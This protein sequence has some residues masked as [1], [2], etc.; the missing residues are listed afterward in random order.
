MEFGL[1]DSGG[2]RGITPECAHVHTTVSAVGGFGPTSRTQTFSS[3]FRNLYAWMSCVHDA[4]RCHGEFSWHLNCETHS[5]ARL[6]RI[7]SPSECSVS[8]SCRAMTWPFLLL[9]VAV[10]TGCGGAQDELEFNA[11]ESA[12]QLDPKLQ[13]HIERELLKEVGTF[14]EPVMLGDDR[15]TTA[16]LLKG[17]AVYQ[18]RCVQCHGVT[19]EGD[20]PTA[21]SM[22]PRPRDYSMG[23]FKFTSTTYGSK[24]M[25]DDL[26]HTVTNGIRGTSMPDFK[27]IPP[28]EIEA[29]VDYVIYLS[30]RGELEDKL[31]YLLG[32]AF[33]GVDPDEIT[34]QMISEIIEDENPVEIVAGSWGRA[35]ESQVLPMTPEPVFTPEHVARGRMAFLDGGTSCFNCHGID[36]RGQTRENLRG[37]RLDTWGNITR[38]ADLTSGML[39]GGRRPIDIYRRIF[40]GINGTPMPAY[41]NNFRDNPD[42]I[43]DLV[44]YVMYL[45]DRRRVGEASAPGPMAPYG[46][47]FDY[48]AWEASMGTAAE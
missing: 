22:Y 23:I 16:W 2:S 13:I 1:R 10:A 6:K 48:D 37:E 38:A 30:R 44:A 45:S 17:Q 26:I 47:Q 40:A 39:H 19:G 25:R 31:T 11:S 33:D 24:P 32:D 35:A 3:Q 41:A 9:F 43:W 20:G 27:L 15:V 5:R 42:K 28:D 36:G 7:E 34:D 14:A 18:E 21:L 46:K 8:S 12:T 4:L 29:V